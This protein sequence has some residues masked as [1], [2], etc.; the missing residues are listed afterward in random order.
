MQQRRLLRT[1]ITGL[2]T[3]FCVAASPLAAQTIVD[4]WAGAKLPPPPQLKT[5][6][7]E[8][9]QSALLVMDFTTQTCSKERRPRCAASVPKVAKLVGEARAKGMLVIYSIAGTGATPASIVQELGPAPG[10]TILPALGPDKFIGSDLEQMLKAR[11]ITTVVAVGT[12]AQTSVLHTAGAAALRGFTVVVPVDGMSSDDAF[13]EL[14]TAW[15]LSTASRIADKV[16]LTKTDM[17]QF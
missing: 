6:K 12:Q 1:G 3:A 2:L 10:E 5:A 7:V 16:T 4:E 8:A 11:G 9:K 14:Y 17:V 13:P 15:H